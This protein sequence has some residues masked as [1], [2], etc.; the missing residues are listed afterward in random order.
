MKILWGAAAGVL[1]SVIG[2]VIAIK[3]LYV[4][5][6]LL[7]QQKISLEKQWREK[8]QAAIRRQ[9]LMNERQLLQ[10]PYRQQLKN[11]HQPHTNTDLYPQIA[12][13]AQ[14][15]GLTITELKPQS[16]RIIAQLKQETWGID[17]SGRE[18]ALFDL[19][20]RLMQQ[21]WL[22]EIQQL[23]FI[24]ANPGVH[25]KATWVIYYG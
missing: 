13:L 15:C 1:I 7:Q 6:K 3:P 17:I 23:E 16:N 10:Q 25:L 22:L 24:P 14:S 18:T 8:Q 2:F 19:M 12:G 20:K 9:Q 4:D 11:L 21:P 5:L